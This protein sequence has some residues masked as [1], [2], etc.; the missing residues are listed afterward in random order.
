MTVPCRVQD[1]GH[2]VDSDIM[3]GA[4]SQ[5]FCRE[6]SGH[7]VLASSLGP[8]RILPGGEKMDR[9]GTLELKGRLGSCGGQH[10]GMLMLSRAVRGLSPHVL[11]GEEAS[12]FPAT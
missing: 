6:H 4:D 8:V 11:S 9:R 10:E 12:L 5:S 7:S 2:S 1:S 3:S